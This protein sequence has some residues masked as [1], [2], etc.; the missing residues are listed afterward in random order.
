[1]SIFLRT[2]LKSLLTTRAFTTKSRI[3]APKQ[4]WMVI[5]PDYTGKLAERNQVRA[6]HLNNTK[7]DVDTGLIVLGGAMLEEPIKEGVP[8][9]MKGSVLMCVADTE[10][11]VLERVKKDVYYTSDVWDKEKVQIFPFKSAIRHAA[12]YKP[13]SM[14]DPIDR[15]TVYDT[16]LSDCLKTSRAGREQTTMSKSKNSTTNKKSDNKNE[17]DQPQSKQ[18]AAHLKYTC[19]VCGDK[20]PGSE[21]SKHFF[22]KSHKQIVEIVKNFKM[23]LNRDSATVRLDSNVL[24]NGNKGWKCLACNKD[25]FPSQ[26]QSLEKHIADAENHGKAVKELVRGFDLRAK[27]NGR[28][29]KIP[30]TKEA[31]FFVDTGKDTE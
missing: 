15:Y 17:S 12:A 5:L 20:I 25:L 3:M 27:E 22:S 19:I 14:P 8:P 1:M 10:E 6:D 9:K 26:N 16:P 13:S 4:E 31:S 21:T 29:G 23:N 18:L 30:E 7:P 24:R 2:P 28:P 11:E